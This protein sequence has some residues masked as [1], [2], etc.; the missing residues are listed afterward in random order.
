MT[1]NERLFYNKIKCLELEYKI[2]PQVSLA[3]IISKEN[4][5]KYY[6]DLFRNIDFAI[7][8]T[9]LQDVLLLIELN[10]GTHKLKKRKNRDAK[11]KKICNAA[12]IPLLFFYTKY[13]NEKDYVINRIRNV[14]NKT[15]EDNLNRQNN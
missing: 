15:K 14:I 13:P 12:G 1:N 5:N 7:F 6:T 9:N 8:D 4:N 11:I 3:S 2:I 10:D